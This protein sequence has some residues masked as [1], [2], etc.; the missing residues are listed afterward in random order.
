MFTYFMFVLDLEQRDPNF[1]S[2]LI[3]NLNEEQRKAVH[4]IFT[5]ADQRKEA[6]LSKEIQKRGGKLSLNH[7]FERC[8]LLSKA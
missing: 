2:V 6:A 1:Y 7:Y 5:L 3:M 4:E 8:L